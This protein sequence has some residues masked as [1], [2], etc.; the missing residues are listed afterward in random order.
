MLTPRIPVFLFA[1]TLAAFAL[2]FFVLAAFVSSNASAQLIHSSVETHTIAAKQIDVKTG[3]DSSVNPVGISQASLVATAQSAHAGMVITNAWPNPL[4]PASAFHL[5]ILTDK[6]G[7]VTAGIYDLEGT[8][9]GM[10]DLGTLN[11]GTN[12]LQPAMPDLPSGEYLIR[13]QQ[14]NDAPE[15]VRINYVK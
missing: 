7:A 11:A 10:L 9:K 3:K 6:E 1:S 4:H 8:Q 2:A 14:G 15:I 5:E 12:E 13:I